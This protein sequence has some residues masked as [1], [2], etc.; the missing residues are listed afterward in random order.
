MPRLGNSHPGRRDVSFRHELARLAAEEAIA[1]HRRIALHRAVL[2]A[3]AGRAGPE[4]D[5]ARLAYHAEAAGDDEQV[6]RWAPPA[7]ERAA[8]SGAHREAAAQYARALRVGHGLSLADRARLLAGRAHE[9]YM[10]AQ[11]EAAIVAQRE[12][13]DVQRRL[14]DPLG[15]GD[16]LRALSRL[17]FFS[18]QAAEGE[19]LAREAVLVLESAPAGHELAMAYGN[20]S[21]RRMVL[22]DEEGAVAW[23]NRAL[24]LAGELDDA[25]ATVYAL[26]NVGAAEFQAGSDTG[27]EKLQQ[28]VSL[29]RRDGLEEY[30][31]RALML[32]T[33]CPLRNARLELTD[34]S[35]QTGLE[36][37]GERGL[38]TWRL[39]LL[40]LRSRLELIRGQ[41]DRSAESAELVLRDPRSAPWATAAAL[42]VVG[43]LRARRGEEDPL[44]PLDDAQAL[45]RETEE[46]DRIAHVA[47]ARAEAAWLQGNDPAVADATGA[48]L[49]MA[50]ERRVPMAVGELAYW[51]W[52]AGHRDDLPSDLVPEPYRSSIAGDW[53]AAG[54]QW[55]AIGAPYHAALAE[56]A[57]DDP[58]VLRRAIEELQQMGARPAATVIARRLREQGVRGIPRGPRRETRQNPSGL[59]PRELEVLALVAEG[60]RNTQIAQ[61]LVVSEKTVDHHVSAILR[62]LD[63]HSRGEAAAQAHRLGLLREL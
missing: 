38:D 6:L 24:T 47:A 34:E 15:E 25:E 35:L 27:R 46:V 36:Y 1:P 39:Y 42:C 40:S 37:C 4:P 21:Q 31:G 57:A 63:V 53:A 22:E 30:A 7:A 17:L 41:W 56:A 11:F 26:I 3:L 20:L 59:T 19:L 54:E 44:A 2:D 18:G 50:L 8:R 48:A 52:Q 58:A 10:T 45:V 43:T 32:L 12:A 60:L 33:L 62:K 55:R 16:A 61:R 13:L 9:C 28:A 49:T 14:G 23:G 29:A 5:L 51:R